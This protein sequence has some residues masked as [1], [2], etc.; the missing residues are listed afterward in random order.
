[1]DKH[2]KQERYLIIVCMVIAVVMLLSF[3]RKLF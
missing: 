1:M 3:I 2:K